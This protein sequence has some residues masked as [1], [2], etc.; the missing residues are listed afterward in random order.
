M[1]SNKKG[2]VDWFI[3]TII[4]SV[5]TLVVF[6][7]V[8]IFFPFGQTI[9]RAACAESI[10]L[11]ATLPGDTVDV[12]SFISVRCK[13]RPI[14]IT[15]KSSG[16]GN[17]TNLG[18]S[19]ETMRLAGTT[20]ADREQQ[21]KMFLA[22]EMADCWSMFGEGKLQIFS[23]DFKAGSYISRGII[24]D[25]IE[26]DNTI[27]KDEGIT[28]LD[29]FT[30]YMVTHKVPGQ[31]ISYMDYLRNT[32]EGESAALLYGPLV[33]PANRTKN[34]NEDKVSLT[35][36]KSIVYIESTLTNFWKATGGIATGLIGAVGG[37]AVTGNIQ[38][39]L[40]KKGTLSGNNQSGERFGQSC[41]C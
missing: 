19:F 32:P 6:V 24:C 17:C 16:K 28:T 33:A 10:V 40:I 5:L 38:A 7:L 2:D 9:D 41:F 23:R 27:L 18:A 36:V 8:A 14:C 1:I 31:N 11:R 20:K 4:I 35:G 21:I 13:S 30:E 25:R 26:F 39:S 22:R 34:L 3:V 12:K 29:G 15:I 37:F